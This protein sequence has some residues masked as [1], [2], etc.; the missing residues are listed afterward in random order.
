MSNPAARA[1]AAGTAWRRRLATALILLA[2]VL[3]AGA[4]AR[5]L[6]AYGSWITGPRFYP[7]LGPGQARAFVAGQAA[8]WLPDVLSRVAPGQEVLVPTNPPRDQERLA[9]YYLYPRPVRIVPTAAGHPFS[10]RPSPARGDFLL[11][12][13]HLLEWPSLAPASVSRPRNSHD[14]PPPFPSPRAWLALLV[15]ALSSLGWGTIFLRWL[16]LRWSLRLSTGESRVVQAGLGLLIGLSFQGAVGFAAAYAGWSATPWLTVSLSAG[17]LVLLWPFARSLAGGRLSASSQPGQRRPTFTPP[18]PFTPSLGRILRPVLIFLIGLLSLA[19]LARALAEPMHHWDERF[20]WAFKG[21]ILLE[22]GG[23]MGPTFQ[24]NGRLHLH[25]RYPLLVPALEAHLARLA[26]GFA[27]ERAVKGLFPL[28]FAALLA[29]AYGTFRCRLAPFPALVWTTLLA[30]LPPFHH[31]SLIQGGPAHTGFADLPLAALLAGA[32]F[33]LLFLLEDPGASTAR[34]LPGS[35]PGSSGPCLRLSLAVGFLAGCAALTKPE[36]L[37]IAVAILAVVALAAP[38][39][40]SAG[41]KALASALLVATVIAMPR[42]A[43]RF[44]VPGAGTL[45]YTGDA[46]YLSRL[47][48]AHLVAGL[49]DHL[50][51]ALGALITAPF[52]S[53]WAFLGLLLA[54]G[55]LTVPASPRRHPHRLALLVLIPLAADGLAFILSTSDIHWHLAVALDRLWMQVLVPAFMVAGGQVASLLE[56]PEHFSPG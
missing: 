28:F 35:P 31:A 20:Q 24:E 10:P 11:R 27:Q 29:V 55:L 2:L 42:L 26:G 6:L 44:V 52:S 43:M 18:D 4:S 45:D 22:E 1:R 21:K 8:G 49:R 34:A 47:A 17:G 7:R 14:F 25:R 13:G 5:T 12:D 23:L 30:A 16:R 37:A 53:R 36:G 54:G 32:C 46:A 51:P 48:P 50:A 40:G 38:R 41:W 3:A 33:L 56:G 19:P 15:T 39:H 9:A